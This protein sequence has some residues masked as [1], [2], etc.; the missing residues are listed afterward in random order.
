VGEFVN[1][2]VIEG[3]VGSVRIDRPK[4]NALNAQLVSELGRLIQRAGEDDS[5]R[6]LVIWGGDR[7]F[8]AGADINEMSDLDPVA[9]YRYI[10]LFH[11]VFGALER[12][13]IVTV[14]AV[15]GFA[16]GGGC[17]LALACD[18]RVGATDAALGQPEIALGI[19]PGAGGTQRLPRLIGIARAKDLIYSGRRVGAEE[20]LSSGL[21]DRVVAPQDVHTDAVALAARYARGPTVALAA[22]KQ[23]IQRGIEMSLD[24][25]LLLERHAF[26]A[27]FATED[28]AI[29]MASFVERGPGR[30]R[31]VGR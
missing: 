12:L 28:Q 3:G 23:A 19:I 10:G 26:S 8:A 11:D 22:A 14:A 25:G 1:M 27:L 9:M 29:G 20:A 24:A 31:F 2:E 7:V 4:V 21:L 17:E 13:P 16:L 30:A 6:A 5:V 15:N 18:F